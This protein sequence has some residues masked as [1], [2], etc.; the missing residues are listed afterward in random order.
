MCN[1]IAQETVK[2]NHIWI[3]AY[4]MLIYNIYKLYNIYIYINI[5]RRD[6]LSCG[7]RIARSWPPLPWYHGMAYLCFSC[8]SSKYACAIIYYNIALAQRPIRTYFRESLSHTIL[9]IA[10]HCLLSSAAVE[11]SEQTSCQE[12]LRKPNSC[13]WLD[14]GCSILCV[15]GVCVCSGLPLSII[16]VWI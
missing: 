11:Y 2:I 10:G 15:D 5:C 7:V 1:P 13:P 3:S 9:A 14:L 16:E 4:D 6:I 8:T 12:G